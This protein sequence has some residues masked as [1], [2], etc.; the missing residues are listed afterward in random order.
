MQKPLPARPS[1]EQFRK[2]AKELVKNHRSRDAGALAL[3]REFFPALARKTDEE[4]IL[5]PFALHDAQWVV[6]RQYGLT[7][8]TE[9]RDRVAALDG[10]AAP[11]AEASV[12]AKFKAICEAYQR[13]DYGLFASVMNETMRTAIPRERFEGVASKLAGYFKSAYAAAYF[14]EMIQGE[15]SVYFWRVSA[16][17]KS[18]D[19]MAR[20]GVKDDLVSGLLFSA[21][22]AG[23]PRN[24][25]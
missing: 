24:E 23:S 13:D 8:W 18:T 20:M 11:V 21:P 19:L 17:G 9:L 22:F 3:I 7:S 4:I 15:H 16:P 25:K 5:F 10:K 2:Q 14:G 12:E 6:A 1:L